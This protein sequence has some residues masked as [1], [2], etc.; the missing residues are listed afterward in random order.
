MIWWK[1]IWYLYAKWN[2]SCNRQKY[3]SYF[4]TCEQTYQQLISLAS[5]YVSYLKVFLWRCGTEYY[6]SNKKHKKFLRTKHFVSSKFIEYTAK[7][8]K[9]MFRGAIITHETINAQQEYCTVL[10]RS[11]TYWKLRVC[12]PSPYTVIGCLRSACKDTHE[13]YRS[14]LQRMVQLKTSNTWYVANRPVQQN[15]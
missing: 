14:G 3:W 5:V 15:C 10:T 4:F 7:L 9:K 2:N 13:T 11:E 1:N 12:F 6:W 8:Q